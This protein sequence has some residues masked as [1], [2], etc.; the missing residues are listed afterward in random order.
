MGWFKVDDQLAFHQKAVIAGN[1]AMGLWVR[2]GS[3]S[4]AQLTDGFIASAMANAMA[5]ECDADALVLAGLWDEVEGG[6]QFHDWSEFQPSAEEEKEKRK[7]RS[8]AGKKGA[9]ARWGNKTD[10]KP[11]GKSHGKTMRS[12]CPDP[13]PEPKDIKESVSGKPKARRGENTPEHRSADAAYEATGKAFNFIAVRA[14]TKWMIHERKL[15][16]EQSTQAIVDTYRAGKPITKTVLGQLIDGYN[17]GNQNTTT[18]R[19]NQTMLLAQE[20]EQ[21][22]QGAI[23]Q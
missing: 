9:E 2:A 17:R 20:L 23:E 21:S 13:D 1:A 11:H 6:Y 18:N 7:A 14:M 5:N 15:T 22:N 3:W 4:C 19:M 16:E 12:Q 8:I 10:S